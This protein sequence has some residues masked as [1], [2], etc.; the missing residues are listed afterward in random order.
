MYLISI[1]RYT[2][3]LAA[4]SAEC[5]D[6]VQNHVTCEADHANEL[7]IPGGNSTE[8]G[9]PSDTISKSSEDIFISIPPAQDGRP[10]STAL[11]FPLPNSI[12]YTDTFHDGDSDNQGHNDSFKI[13]QG[14]PNPHAS[15]PHILAVAAEAAD[16][17]A[18][19]DDTPIETVTPEILSTLGDMGDVYSGSLTVELVEETTP[20]TSIPEISCV[21]ETAGTAATLDCSPSGRFAIGPGVYATKQNPKEFHVDGMLVTNTD[22]L[23][24]SVEQSAIESGDESGGNSPGEYSSK[25]EGDVESSASVGAESKNIS[26]SGK[27]QPVEVDRSLVECCAEG[28][29][30]ADTKEFCESSVNQVSSLLAEVTSENENAKREHTEKPL[31]VFEQAVGLSGENVSGNEHCPSLAKDT[32]IEAGLIKGETKIYSAKAAASQEDIPILVSPHLRKK[33]EPK[34]CPDIS[35]SELSIV[36]VMS[37]LSIDQFNKS[38]S[39]EEFINSICTADLVNIASNV[40]SKSYGISISTIQCVVDP[41]SKTGSRN[42]I[43]T[44]EFSE[45]GT[46]RKHKWAILI[47]LRGRC[48]SNAEKSWL[49]SDIRAM[50]FIKER[51]DIPIPYIY[52]YDH[53]TQNKIGT[54]Y[55]LMDFMEGDRVED[56]WENWSEEKRLLCLSQCAESMRKLGR[57]GFNCIGVLGCDHR[58]GEYVVHGIP[59]ETKC[60]GDGISVTG[61]F[62]STKAYLDNIWRSKTMEL[63]G[64]ITPEAAKNKQFL[65]LLKLLIPALV[66]LGPATQHF[67]LS[68]PGFGG[69]N[70]LVDH[71]GNVTGFVGWEKVMIMP[72]AMGYARYPKWIIKDWISSQEKSLALAKQSEKGTAKPKVVPEINRKSLTKASLGSGKRIE[73]VKDSKGVIRGYL[74]EEG[75]DF[76]GKT[77]LNFKT[78]TSSQSKA[79][80]DEDTAEELNDTLRAIHIS[81]DRLANLSSITTPEELPTISIDCPVPNDEAPGEISRWKRNKKGRKEGYRNNR[82]SNRRSNRDTRQPAT[83]RRQEYDESIELQRATTDHDKTKVHAVSKWNA[84]PEEIIKKEAE[85]REERKQARLVKEEEDKVAGIKKESPM[86]PKVVETFKKVVVE[87]NLERKLLEVI[88]TERKCSPDETIDMEDIMTTSM[89]QVPKFSD[90]V[91]YRKIY[92]G[93]FAK[94]APEDEMATKYSHMSIAIHTAITNDDLRS[95]IVPRLAKHVF[96]VAVG[97]SLLGMVG[98]GQW[99]KE[100]LAKLAEDKYESKKGVRFAG[101]DEQFAVEGDGGGDGSVW[102]G[103][104][105]GPALVIG[106]TVVILVVSVSLQQTPT[107]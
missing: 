48:Y 38:D 85:E 75:E 35:D 60:S 31:E 24:V 68:L 21:T 97:P 88:K 72:K 54:P 44:A 46:D 26:K 73:A 96:G 91:R 59:S 36:S 9:D 92:H 64:D 101:E 93:L 50:E 98:N 37:T 89:P 27:E 18:A 51:T 47:P 81:Q 1:T 90:I 61:P 62:S 8:T 77:I 40:Y 22:N 30:L 66:D 84:L 55:V 67:F 28:C 13:Q 99:A 19:L 69:G 29:V 32:S 104:I 87:Q 103:L 10:P 23:L 65:V 4:E 53:S 25:Q 11:M 80:E 3:T 63:E 34:P 20:S 12:T 70:V 100:L 83:R 15:T 86:L 71:D 6:V 76:L 49:E 94:I 57:F 14:P 107:S 74:L 95:S 56:V 58:K 52:G 39:I 43:Y 102:E 82:G 41:R 78:S 42:A 106:V 45:K 16:T 2:N 33:P 17:A 105:L 7:D 5:G 79:S